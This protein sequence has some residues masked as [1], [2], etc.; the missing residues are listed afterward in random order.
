MPEDAPSHVPPQPEISPSG[1]RRD[2]LKRAAC[3]VLGGVCVLAPAAAGVAVLLDPLL[4]RHASGIF[5]R[6]TSLDL[7]PLGG[8]PRRF[9]VMEARRS[10]WTKYPR[11]PIGSVYLQR[12]GEREVRAFNASCPHLG[13]SVE[14]EPKR[15]AYFCPCHQSDFALDGAQ[16][17]A[18][19]S[20]RPLDSLPIEIRG[21]DE[22]WVRFQNFKATIKEKIPVA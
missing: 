6:L 13:C 10:A 3:G 18:S 22:V 8:P 9:E 1:D 19:P 7:L 11:A 5:V 20:A 2:F 17:A 21:G 16:S 12:T 15:N 4:R 14:F